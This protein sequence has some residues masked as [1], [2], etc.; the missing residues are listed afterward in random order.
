MDIF[1]FLQ[2]AEVAPIDPELARRRWGVYREL[3]GFRPGRPLFSQPN[4]NLK[5][6]KAGKKGLAVT[7]G[8][9]LAQALV[10][11]HQACRYSTLACTASCVG[12]NGNRRY[13]S[14]QAAAIMRTRWLMTDPSAFISLMAAE[15]DKAYVRH[16][17]ALQVR[18][19]TF[20]DIPWEGVALWLFTDRPHVRMYDYT[21]WPRRE[22][23][24]N[25][26][27]TFSASERTPDQEIVERV[28]GGQNVAVVFSTPRSK[29][30]PD[31][32][33]GLRVIDGDIHD[34]RWLDPRGVVV[35][36]RAKGRMRRLGG[37]MV[38]V[39]E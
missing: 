16:G 15:V 2:R 23:P 35:G 1:R 4:E 18:L 25:Y 19:N 34:A 28:R 5:T 8:L 20:S 33:K 22:A 17:D 10:S 3:N 7:M 29:P 11:G 32:W 39:V 36:L 31:E 12:M 26:H 38:R 24:E 14:V 6:A 13:S 21:K 9:A 37:A 27:L 30:L